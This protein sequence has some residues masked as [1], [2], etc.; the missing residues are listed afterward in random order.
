M[1]SRPPCAPYKKRLTI[2]TDC[3]SLKPIY[4]KVA[5]DYAAEPDVIIA[6]VDAE[7]EN[8]KSLAQEQGITE[9]E[10]NNTRPN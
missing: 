6:Q 2:L 8:S 10:L 9:T 5:E 4:E 7:A 1:L 3:K